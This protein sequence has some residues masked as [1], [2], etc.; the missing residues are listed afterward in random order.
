MADPVRPPISTDADKPIRF[1]PALCSV[2]IAQSSSATSPI[3]FKGGIASDHTCPLVTIS[4][5]MSAQLGVGKSSSQIGQTSTKQCLHSHLRASSSQV[6]Q[7]SSIMWRMPNLELIQSSARTDGLGHDRRL[8]GVAKTCIGSPAVHSRQDHAGC[9][10]R[11]RSCTCWHTHL[12]TDVVRV[13][14]AACS[15]VTTRIRAIAEVDT[16]VPAIDTEPIRVSIGD[17]PSEFSCVYRN[18]PALHHR[19]GTRS[20]LHACTG[21]GGGLFTSTNPEVRRQMAEQKSSWCM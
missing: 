9:D 14:Q 2:S 13:S 11:S 15:C 1:Y 17:G 20:Q 7:R 18:M 3:T 4:G 21:G 16:L 10:S 6:R 19:P 8:Q 12:L 5:N